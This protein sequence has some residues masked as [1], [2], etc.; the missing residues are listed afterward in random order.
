MENL[1]KSLTE[2]IDETL[3]EIE[4][5]KKSERYSANEIE[6][7]DEKANGSMNEKSIQKGEEEKEDKAHEEAESEEEEKAEHTKKSDDEEDEEEDDEDMSK[8]ESDMKKAEDACAKA[9]KK[10]EMCKAEAEHKKKMYFM[11]KGEAEKKDDKEDKKEDEK[12]LKK[13]ID[14]RVAPIE[15]KLSEV[16]SAVKKLSEA[17]AAPRGVSYRDVRPLAKSLEVETLSKSQVLNELVNLKKSGKEV[18]SEDV[19]QVE[20]GSADHLSIARKYGIK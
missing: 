18:L 1:Q 2:L 12:E 14:A 19:I 20:D 5:L 10:Y 8:A 4:A 9:L 3:A 11:K 15:S 17:P 16:L 6:L 7:G 13:S